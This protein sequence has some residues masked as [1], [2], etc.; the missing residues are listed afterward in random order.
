MKSVIFLASLLSLTTAF[1]FIL[2]NDDQR[3]FLENLAFDGHFRGKYH[4][5][6]VYN[7]FM[8]TTV[9]DPTGAVILHDKA[10]DDGIIEF[11][12]ET[13][14]FHQICF[15][16]RT[17]KNARPGN[18]PREV[19]FD[20]HTHAGDAGDIID[21][22]DVA[23]REHL[24]PTEVNLRIVD[25]NLRA[26]HDELHQLRAHESAMADAVDTVFFYISFSPVL[27]AALLA[28]FVVALLLTR[29]SLKRR[30]LL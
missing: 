13:M 19:T 30:S 7:Q 8:D 29:R 18:K 2:R 5:T 21:Y 25:D 12:A 22:A 1:V 10:D 28:V 26:V 20:V 16:T 23:R 6:H 24:Q 11:T 15:T 27:F 9:Q 4:S 3:C 14:G 17:L